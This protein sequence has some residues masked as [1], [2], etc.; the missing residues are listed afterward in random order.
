MGELTCF[1]PKTQKAASDEEK[2]AHPGRLPLIYLPD[3]G[4]DPK[5]AA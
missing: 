4:R 1:H 2:T 3:N 5:V